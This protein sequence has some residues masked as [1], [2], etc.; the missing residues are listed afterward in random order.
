M[1]CALMFANDSTGVYAENGAKKT[2]NPKAQ[3]LS[4]NSLL[5]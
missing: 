1:A 3:G 4:E 2:N 5:Y